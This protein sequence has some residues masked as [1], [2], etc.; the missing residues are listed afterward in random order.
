MSCA[1]GGAVLFGRA[2][3]LD[4]HFE[5]PRQLDHGDHGIGGV[6]VA[7]LEHARADLH[8]GIGRRVAAVLHAEQAVV[9]A[10]DVRIGAD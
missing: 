10:L 4:L 7:R 3:R 6:D 5:L 2:D 8:G 9:A 1:G